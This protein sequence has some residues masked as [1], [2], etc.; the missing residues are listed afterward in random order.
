MG[1]QGL[2]LGTLG[3]I[4]FALARCWKMRLFRDV[5]RGA[6]SGREVAVVCA[7]VNSHFE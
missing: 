6:L 4:G 1:N 5:L 3:A 2:R 7:D